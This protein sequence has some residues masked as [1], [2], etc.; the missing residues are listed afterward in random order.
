MRQ[1][2]FNNSY[3]IVSATVFSFSV[4]GDT[5]KKQKFGKPKIEITDRWLYH[6]AHEGHEVWAGRTKGSVFGKCGLRIA[7]LRRVKGQG[8]RKKAEILKAENR[9][10]AFFAANG[11]KKLC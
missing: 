3:R 10:T 8:H 1:L 11:A 5:E 2:Y 9:N 6:E 7:E 4:F